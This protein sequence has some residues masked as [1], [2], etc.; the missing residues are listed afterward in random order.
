M[1]LWKKYVCKH[2]GSTAL[3]L[4][5]RKTREYIKQQEEKVFDW[6]SMMTLAEIKAQ[7][8]TYLNRCGHSP[9]RNVDKS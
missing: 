7:I 3:K 1:K 8:R 4:H 2:L 9:D 6:A 5:K